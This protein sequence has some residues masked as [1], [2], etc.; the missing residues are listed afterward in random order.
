VLQTPWNLS[1][2]VEQVE[3]WIQVTSLQHATVNEAQIKVVANLQYQI[4]NTGLKA[5]RVSLP[6]NAESVRFQ[7]EQLADFLAVPLTATNGLQTW[8]I[9]L[10]RRVI[11]SYLLQATY[12]TLMPDRAPETVLRGVQAVGVNLQRGFVTVESG[13]RLQL[14]VGTLPEAL[15]PTEWQ[16]IPRVL[17]QDLQSAAANVAYR[18]VEPS[19]DLPLKLE[20]HEATQLLPARVTNVALNS[21]LSDSGVMLTHV[22]LEMLPGDKPELELS[23]PKG[24]AFWFA[25]VNQK[26]V[27]P[28][29][30]DDH[31][32][33][34]LDQ[35]CR[36]GQAIPVELFYSFA[37]GSAS[38]RSLNLDLL[39][40]KFELP[41]ENITWRVSLSEKW[42]VKHWSGTLQL[43]H[44]ETVPEA[45]AVDPK[46][47]LQAEATLQQE[48]TKKAEEFL[49]AGNSALEQGDP[50][51]ARRSFQA[52]YGLSGQDAAFNEDARVQLHN[53][54]LQQALVG[55]NVRQ[56]A[57]AG[58]VGVLGSKFRDLRNRKEL[59][60]T[61]QDAKDIIDRN[62]ADENAAD[63]RLA[64]RLIQ[65]QDAAVTSATAIRASIPEQ[66]RV[67][68]FKRAMLV[69]KWADLSIALKASAAKAAPWTARTLLLGLTLT[70]LMLFGFIAR[71]AQSA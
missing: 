6:T 58:D 42:Q 29:R 16:S 12:Q 69:D 15:Q 1:L 2:D 66:G 54:K 67:L 27:W 38:A 40:P 48:R 37:A 43:A 18:L 61:Q 7:G 11:G 14:Q 62:T 10:R 35:Q 50:Q 22:Q 3:P 70:L 44:Q 17:Q 5:L 45:G 47:Y 49:V 21:T 36:K 30:K 19:F 51:Q 24:A 13:G 8:E 46:N 55:L 23:L 4:E 60:Y 71:R 9:K 25:F 26:A 28:W 31:I 32:L 41:L 65:Q 20:R 33:I 53:I 64:E 56:A 63:M 68:T 34:P 52:A 59:S 39:A 57:A